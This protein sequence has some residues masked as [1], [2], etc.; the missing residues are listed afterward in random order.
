MTPSKCDPHSGFDPD[1]R[2]FHSLRPPISLP[3]L[4]IPFSFPDYVS[5]LH[6]PHTP[7]AFIIDATT[8]RRIS[9]SDLPRLFRTLASNL[10]RRF[11][12]SKGDVAFILSPN[13]I[14]IP[15]LHLALLSLGVVVCPSNPLSSAVEIS[16]QI[17][18][19]K[20]AIAFAASD[21]AS[22][23]PPLRL[24]TVLLDS[25]D[26]DSLLLPRS[27]PVE[28]PVRAGVLQS[29]TAAILYSSGTTG[30]VKGV[31]LTHRNLVAAVASVRAVRSVRPSP[32][33]TLCAVPF[34]H[35][36]GFALCLR[37]VALG[38]SVVV[39][40]RA[41]LGTL[42]GAVEEFKVTHLAA[43]PPTVV[44]MVKTEAALERF[45]L[46]LLE[47]VL[48]GGAPLANSV[49][50]KFKG[51]FGHVSLMQVCIVDYFLFT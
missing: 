30:R 25:P 11:H 38:G 14:H 6:D 33:V 4:T 18:I 34:F 42:V 47:T 3:P 31:E 35:V 44:E 17:H 22:K 39:V 16:R 9:L 46:N 23:F 13:S 43:A 40:D 24:G 5:N 7:T 36:Y 48:C 21:C 8:R 26:F 28:S 32:A 19:T 49:V 27:G 15:L 50:E 29:D 41:Y 45:D 20:P 10:S 37:E 12:L 1:T 51:R 2:I